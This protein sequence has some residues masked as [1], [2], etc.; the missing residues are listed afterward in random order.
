MVAR[1][2]SAND[3][4]SPNPSHQR[5]LAVLEALSQAHVEAK[6]WR[7]FLGQGKGIEAFVCLVMG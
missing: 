7:E 6:D 1:W 5:L 2:E 3:E 4:A